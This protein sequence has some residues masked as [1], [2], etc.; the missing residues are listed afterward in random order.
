LR[1]ARHGGPSLGFIAT[2]RSTRLPSPLLKSSG[3]GALHAGLIREL[4]D[5]PAHRVED[6]IRRAQTFQRGP[7]TE[8]AAARSAPRGQ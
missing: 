6:F 2:P 5:R 4:R 8:A 7:H 3:G 1:G